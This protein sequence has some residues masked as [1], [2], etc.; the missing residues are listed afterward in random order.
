[1]YRDRTTK[2]LSMTYLTFKQRLKK[3]HEQTKTENDMKVKNSIR[4]LKNNKAHGP[5]K[6]YGDFL[7]L[8][9]KK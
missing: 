7:E 6:V 1:M 9:G 4:K 8:I 2:D 5:Y 3:L